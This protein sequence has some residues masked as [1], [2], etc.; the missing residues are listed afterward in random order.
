MHQI[1]KVNTR[2]FNTS[3]N[4]IK[5]ILKAW[6]AITFAFTIAF[7]GFSSILNFIYGLVLS[8]VT[9]GLGFLLHE[10]A[11]KVV[12]QRYGCF[13]E[14]RAFDKMLIVMIFLS[15]LGIVFAAPGAVMIEGPVG[16][17]RNGIISIAGPVVNLILAAIFLVNFFLLPVEFM[18][19]ISYY[20]F[21]INTLLAMFNMIPF[22]I[23]DGAKVWRWSKPA[24]FIT[25][26]IG[27]LFMVIQNFINVPIL[28]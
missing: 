14:F 23:L 21:M 12:A 7:L 5:D 10:L 27:A 26:I 1:K 20:G 24:W 18:K 11:H 13:A 16:K 3:E 28:G 8:A 4:E 9:V 25:I 6:I 19:R 2:I 15:F 22:W 17:K